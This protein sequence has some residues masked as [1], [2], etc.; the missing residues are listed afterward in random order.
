[1][2]SSS[3]GLCLVARPVRGS[4]D[5]TPAGLGWPTRSRA[6]AFT[7]LMAEN[8]V[9]LRFVTARTSME[10]I[11]RKWKCR[12]KDKLTCYGRAR[13]FQRNHGATAAQPDLSQV[14]PSG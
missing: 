13:I 5:S 12:L 6:L 9:G 4:V 7:A 3:L 1:M 11:E 14:R 2:I 8:G 10:E